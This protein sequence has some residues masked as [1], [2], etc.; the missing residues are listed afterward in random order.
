MADVVRAPYIQTGRAFGVGERRLIWRHGL[1]NAALPILTVLG[2][3][4]GD[5]LA[6][7]LL[8]EAVF[9][10]PGLG[11]YTLDSIS[12]LDYPGIIGVSL[13]ITLIYT[14]ANLLI[15]VLY[16]IADPRLRRT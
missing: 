4:F 13:F 2:L 3:S 9:S 11:R 12:T 5:L 7:S 16:P 15:D 1:R 6:G 8:V 14:L 10:W